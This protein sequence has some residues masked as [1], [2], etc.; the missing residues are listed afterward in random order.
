MSITPF[1]AGQSFD[2]EQI[3]VMSAAFVDVC[4]ALSLSE[5]DHHRTAIV[6]RY[7]IELGQRGF[8]NRAVIYFLTLKEFS[9]QKRRDKRLTLLLTSIMALAW[10]VILAAAL[11][12][13][14]SALDVPPND[15]RTY[16]LGSAALVL[17]VVVG[18]SRIRRS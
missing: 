6:A 16:A 9:S 15:I 17:F 1:L 18:V 12:T 13:I 4:N 14:L 7:V 10:A 8:R 2:A 3:D 11:D 5:T